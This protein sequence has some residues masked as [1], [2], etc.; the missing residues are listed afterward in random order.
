[1]TD[2]SVT[3]TTP[4]I[5]GVWRAHEV[6]SLFALHSR[7]FLPNGGVSLTGASFPPQEG[8]GYEA[9]AK[10]ELLGGRLSGQVSG[11]TNTRTNVVQFDRILNSNVLAGETESRGVEFEINATL[12]EGWQTVA[13]YV[14]NDT[15]ISRDVDPTMVG[16]PLANTP[17]HTVKVW[18]RYGWRRGPL[19]GLHLG[20]GFTYLGRTL[21]NSASAT[22]RNLYNAGYR[23]FDLAAGYSWRAG[24]NRWALTANV[25]NLMDAKYIYGQ[26]LRSTPR[27]YEAALRFDY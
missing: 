9:G 20:A 4:M 8:I 17:L 21:A 3:N 19:A 24:G 18:Q 12:G 2:V 13:S 6:V 16:I 11:F 7:S 10:L 26:F 23:V 15:R 25:R 5:G 14:Y 22:D 1:V 27:S